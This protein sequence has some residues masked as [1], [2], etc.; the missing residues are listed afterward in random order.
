MT[1][2]SSYAGAVRRFLAWYHAQQGRALTLAD[3]TEALIS[4][5]WEQ[6]EQDRS[7]TIANT[8]KTA[9]RS[10]CRWLVEAGHLPT[11]PSP[12]RRRRISA[13]API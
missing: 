6:V 1:T 13:R 8:V 7:G 11:N 2:A 5:Y 10:W 3:L 4:A 9:M 12:E